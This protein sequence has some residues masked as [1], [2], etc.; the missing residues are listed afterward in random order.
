MGGKST[1]PGRGRKPKPAEQKRLAGNPGHREI[2]DAAPSCE[3]IHNV[4]PPEWMGDLARGIW[5]TITPHLCEQKVLTV[6]DIHNLEAFCTA[7]SRW[8]IAEKEIVQ[9]G[10][11]TMDINGNWKKNPACT[12]ANEAMR[13]LAMFGSLLGLDPA[14]RQRLIAPSQ[15]KGNPFL[16]LLNAE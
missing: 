2:N 9:R 13:Q 15:V 8:R 6:T 1:L 10:I 12:V 14:S 3:P 16:D 11:T 7:Y 5:L 4:E